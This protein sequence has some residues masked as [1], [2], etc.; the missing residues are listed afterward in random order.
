MDYGMSVL[1]VFL[2]TIEHGEKPDQLNDPA[3]LERWA[4]MNRIEGD[5]VSEADLVMARELREAI[6]AN[7]HDKDASANRGRLADVSVRYSLRAG[8]PTIGEPALVSVG[9]G[10]HGLLGRV[11]AEFA[12]ARATGA[13]ERLKLCA[14]CGWAFTDRSRNRSRR[15]CEMTSCGNQSKVR[16]YRTRRRGLDTSARPANAS[17]AAIK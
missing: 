9:A 11:I 16:A 13:I 10:V 1:E 12:T 7:L 17:V 4:A 2:D 14:N 15:W 5:D 3:G 8:D 6:R